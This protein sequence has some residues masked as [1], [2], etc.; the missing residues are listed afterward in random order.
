MMRF[1]PVGRGMGYKE[2]LMLNA[3][4][5][6]RLHKIILG[7]SVAYKGKIQISGDNCGFFESKIFN[8][9]SEEEKKAF[10]CQGGRSWCVIMPN[11]VI[12]PCDYI[13]FYAGNVRKD[14][15]SKIWESS[16]VF[17]TFRQFNTNSLKGV[18]GSC[19]YK[20]ICGGHCRAMALLFYGDFYESDP[21]CWRVSNTM[22]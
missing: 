2:E 8:T 4:D 15:F 22:L 5:T 9:R 6:Q 7:L 18:C 17:K 14:K 16:P 3:E 10:M 19:E 20:N 11:G 13:T 1:Y 21:T 12:S